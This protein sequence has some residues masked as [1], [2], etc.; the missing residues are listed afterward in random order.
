ML[1][2][3]DSEQRLLDRLV[4]DARAGTSGVLALVGEVGIG[5]TALLDATAERAAGMQVL[6]ARGVES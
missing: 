6:R 4:S 5:K 2:G 3:R 1:L